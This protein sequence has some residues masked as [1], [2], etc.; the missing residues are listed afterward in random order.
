MP[1]IKSFLHSLKSK[2]FL[3]F[4]K[5]RALTLKK[6]IV[7]VFILLILLGLFI[8][9]ISDSKKDN[10]YTL[11]KVKIGNIDEIV[12]ESGNIVSSNKTDIYSPS[13]GIVK[14]IF[15]E[16]GDFVKRGDKLFEVQSSATE[17]EK[18]AA[19]A[20]YLAG[21][22]TLNSANAN[23]DS[24]QSAMFSQWQTFKETAESDRYENSDGTPRYDERSKAE[25]HVAEKN[26]TASEKN[27]KNAQ[28]AIAS[29]QANVNSAKLLLDAT[30]DAIVKATAD[31]YAENISVSKGSGVRVNQAIAPT[32]PVLTLVGDA[33]TEV[34][35]KLGESD[36]VKVNPNQDVSLDINAIKDKVYRGKVMRVDSV[37]TLDQGVV[38]YN[39]YIEILNPDEN[40]KQGMNT[41][42][43]IKT[44]SVKGVLIVPNSSVKPYQGGRA[45]RVV[46]AKSKE[47]K[48]I[49]VKIG[50]KGQSYTQIT[51]GLK[52]GQEVI[53]ALSNDKIKRPG[54]F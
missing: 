40:L 13:N 16:N 45:V 30:K 53:T 37:G 1:K 54:L 35:L 32:N 21:V 23:A 4:L 25:F 11:A 29:A 6:K 47:P 43:D 7:V 39:A 51:E 31:G 34:A 28:T 10:G 26:W 36:V 42:A 46:D 9:V 14:E 24:L 49:P 12:S 27:F 41:D 22:S 15:V 18:Q 48:F 19:Q 2:I 44:K 52:E 3:I 17:Q 38:K 50:L 33:K 20:N 5:F 8:K